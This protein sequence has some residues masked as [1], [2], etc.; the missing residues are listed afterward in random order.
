MARDLLAKGP[1]EDE[2]LKLERLIR[3][4]SPDPRA[5]HVGLFCLAVVVFVVL[6]TKLFG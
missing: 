5:L 2:R 1:S 3:D 4:T 6:L